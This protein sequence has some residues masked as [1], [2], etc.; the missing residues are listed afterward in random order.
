M[1]SST[2]KQKRKLTPAKMML[3]ASGLLIVF[4]VIQYFVLDLAGAEARQDLRMSDTEI[5][6]SYGFDMQ[7]SFYSPG[8]RH[9]FFAARDGV[10]NIS[11]T[12]ELRWQ[13][14]FT[15][16]QPDM[17]GRG[18][19]VAVGE[20]GERQVYVFGP[21]GLLYI[22]DF[23]HPLLYFS[24]NGSGYLSVILR[25]DAGYELRVFSPGN[26]HQ[27]RAYIYRAPINDA[28]VFP[29]TVDVSACGTYIVKGFVDVNTLMTSRV[30]FSYIRRVDSRGMPDGLFA[31][32]NF[33]DELI[34]RARFT[35]SQ[36]VIVLT[37]HQII[38]FD[39][40]KGTQGPLWS[41]PLHN[42]PDKFDIGETH[43]AFVTGSQFL[44]R[45]EAESA[46]IVHIYD[47][48]GNLT[49]SYDLGRRAT[50][51]S[52]G[53]GAV[54]AGTDRTFYAINTQGT[55]LWSYSAIQDVQD[56]IFLDNTDTILLAGGARATVMRR[57]R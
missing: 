54:L 24:I 51:L 20:R 30:T 27:D 21:A 55:R 9:F 2:K 36:R 15:M 25:T 6:I 57:L 32:Y 26:P 3:I 53:L 19:M 40:G 56:M 41:I 7:V 49:G 4:A 44:N 31:S 43:F 17:V 18:G 33:R 29:F 22:A 37:D 42:M 14:G 28:N 10:Q 48:N 12:G 1:D 35:D 50:H 5:G 11:S 16:S 52:M 46:G 38:G 39:V 23:P 47:F 8:G 45:P 34:L 13:H